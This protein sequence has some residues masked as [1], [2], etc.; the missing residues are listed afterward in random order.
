MRVMEARDEPGRV[1]LVLRWTR[2][3]AED[4]PDTRGA[5]DLIGVDLVNRRQV[6]MTPDVRDYLRLGIVPEPEQDRPLPSLASLD[7]DAMP[8]PGR[9]HV[10]RASVTTWNGNRFEFACHDT[11]V[12]RD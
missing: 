8:A 11:F 10:R 7:T 2:A 9:P 6:Q 1:A 12:E 5:R 3:R 4:R